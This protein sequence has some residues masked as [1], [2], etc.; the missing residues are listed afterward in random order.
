VSSHYPT[1]SIKTGCCGPCMG[2]CGGMVWSVVCCW[3]ACG[4]ATRQTKG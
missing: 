3:S 4:A 1:G 2:C